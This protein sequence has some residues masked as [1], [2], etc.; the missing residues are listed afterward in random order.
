[1]EQG[2]ASKKEEEERMNL[3][4]AK[5]FQRMYNEGFYREKAALKKAALESKKCRSDS[6]GEAT[7]QSSEEAV[8]STELPGE[9]GNKKIVQ[10]SLD[11]P[12]MISAKRT[13]ML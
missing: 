4:C 12:R 6:E 1:M 10:A 2:V 9:D 5:E 13:R 7:L 3:E 11:T 8:I